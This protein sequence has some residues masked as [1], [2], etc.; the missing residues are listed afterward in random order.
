MF[1][2]IAVWIAHSRR[3]DKN[4]VH[5]EV[6]VCILLIMDS[7]AWAFRG[8][9]GTLGFWMV[10]IS[11]LCVFVLNYL[12]M[13]EFSQYIVSCIED[14]EEK[15]DFPVNT[16]IWAIYMLGV[17]GIALV[18]INFFTG[19]FY[20]FDAMNN[21]YRTENYYIL[22]M[23]AFI[24]SILNTAFLFLNRKYF[25]A[26]W[27][28]CLLSYLILPT[29]AG[30]FQLFHYGISLIN[31]SMALAMLLI[32][33]AWQI[34][35]SEKQM[36]QEKELLEHKA[37]M[38]EQEKK[39]VSMQQDIMLSQIQPHFLYNSL[40]AIAQL[41]EK[42]PARAKRATISF[43]DYL[44]GNMDSLK[45]RELIPFSKELEHIESYLCLEQI[46]F[47]DQLEIIFD[48]ETVDFQVPV[49]SV[50][51]VVENAVKHGIKRQGTVVIR[52]QEKA[53]WYEIQVIDDGVG[54]DPDEKK[55]DGRSHIGIENVKSRLWDMCSGKLSYASSPGEGTTVTIWIPKANDKKE[56]EF[57]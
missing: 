18:C 9:P 52:T 17:T 36:L 47:G 50:Q 2:A 37:K 5:M 35:K 12:V 29:A 19:L 8:Y 56:D 34:D 13:V 49:L 25:S 32:F 10:R 53:E 11:N 1:C 43:A 51:P 22:M 55:E 3:I 16:W 27:F 42:D 40:T 31:I 48:I 57:V 26:K 24:G 14:R 54:F 45:S 15:V 6:M 23:L 33:F 7:L 39:I 38:A 44:R 30:V 41:C 28:W 4:I 20:D 21:Y 46:R